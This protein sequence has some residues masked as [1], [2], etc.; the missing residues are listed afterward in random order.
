MG[1][2][3]E[4]PWFWVVYMIAVVLFVLAMASDDGE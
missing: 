2:L 4:N 1:A 3:V